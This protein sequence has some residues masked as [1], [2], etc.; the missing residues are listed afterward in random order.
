M[1]VMH[2]NT[3]E[4]L[5]DTRDELR[6]ETIKMM[7]QYTANCFFQIG[8]NRFYLQITYGSNSIILLKKGGMVLILIY[9]GKCFLVAHLYTP[10]LP[11]LVAGPLKR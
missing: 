4:I 10:P 8:S 7:P 6:W 9:I 11:L 2:E 1:Y 5:S 3:Y